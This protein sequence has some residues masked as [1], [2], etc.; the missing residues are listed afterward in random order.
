MAGLEFDGHSAG[1]WLRPVSDRPSE[2]VSEYERQYVDGSDPRVLD[3]ID[4]PLLEHRPH[5]HQVENWLLDPQYYWRRV[6]R[7]TPARL[8]TFA[9]APA[10]LWLDGHKTRDGQN[11]RIPEEFLPEVSSSLRLIH[12]ETLTVAVFVQDGAY[13]KRRVQ[14]RFLHATKPYAFWITDPTIERKYLAQPDGRYELGEC[15][16][17]I[18]IGEPFEG[19][20]YKLI[21]AVIELG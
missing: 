21:A 4:V 2:E 17:T 14:G 16:L 12:V 1:P 6:D 20:C 9:E 10:A 19:A 11:D 7:V 13:P 5:Q 15:C 8:R 3:V 18:S